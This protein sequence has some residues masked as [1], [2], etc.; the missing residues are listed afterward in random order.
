M[1]LT[2][3]EKVS[4][5][6]VVSTAIVVLVTLFNFQINL[7]KPPKIVIVNQTITKT[8]YPEV[9]E[10]FIN[11][12]IELVNKGEYAKH[13]EVEISAINSKGEKLGLTVIELEDLEKNLLV[14]KEINFTVPFYCD[15]V[16][17][18]GVEL[19]KFS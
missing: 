11:G 4:I 12:T 17:G 8:Q 7:T 3:Y 18:L 2:P 14:K 6:L 13:A 16:Y 10:C 15:E 5:I 19:K 1:K 9:K